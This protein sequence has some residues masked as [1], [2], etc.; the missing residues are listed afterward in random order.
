MIIDMVELGCMF[1]LVAVNDD[2]ERAVPKEPPYL[3]EIGEICKR[4]DLLSKAWR[5]QMMV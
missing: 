4:L 1:V 2:I 3:L 5:P